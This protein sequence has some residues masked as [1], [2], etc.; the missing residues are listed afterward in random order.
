MPTGL[1][2]LIIVGEEFFPAERVIR[3][4]FYPLGILAPY[5]SEQGRA[6]FFRD[7]A[8]LDDLPL[9]PV[10]MPPAPFLVD[11]DRARIITYLDQSFLQVIEF[12]RRFELYP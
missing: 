10:K 6:F 2:R 7:R 3:S 9:Q 4:F 12:P 1:C 11:G 5:D 8:S